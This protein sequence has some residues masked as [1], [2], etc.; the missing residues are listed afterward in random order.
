MV[1]E[2]DANWS[3][4]GMNQEKAELATL[5]EGK[6]TKTSH[7]MDNSICTTDSFKG[8]NKNSPI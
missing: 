5:R 2:K 1:W 6:A 3:Q 4:Y 7:S 8:R